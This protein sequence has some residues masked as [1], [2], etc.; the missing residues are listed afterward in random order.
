MQK[1]MANADMTQEDIERQR[2]DDAAFEEEIRIER[3]REA[4]DFGK[5][6]VCEACSGPIPEGEAVKSDGCY[7]HDECL[8]G[9][10]A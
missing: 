8:K 2:Q 6:A 7:F 9:D 10:D 1:E 5:P 4:M 3:N